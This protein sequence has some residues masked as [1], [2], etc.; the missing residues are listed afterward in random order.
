MKKIIISSIVS[1]FLGVFLTSFYMNSIKSKNIVKI[2]GKIIFD[3]NFY[4]KYYFM[5]RKYINYPVVIHDKIYLKINNKEDLL[6]KKTGDGVLVTGHLYTVH[7]G[8]GQK[9]TEIDVID[10]K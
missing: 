8:D 7:L 2:S 6:K 5:N 10:I 1:L 9:V 4:K 3:S